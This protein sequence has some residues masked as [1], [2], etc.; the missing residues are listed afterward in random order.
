MT[1]GDIVFQGMQVPDILCHGTTMQFVNRFRQPDG[2]YRVDV[3]NE[4]CA[5]DGDVRAWPKHMRPGWEHATLVIDSFRAYE[6]LRDIVAGCVFKFDFLP[7]GSYAVLG[8]S[9]WR[10]PMYNN[11]RNSLKYEIAIDK[12][13]KCL[14][15]TRT[16]QFNF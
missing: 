12:L 8:E 6:G 5:R 14:R 11:D 4:I 16:I 1:Q 15:E 10:D 13:A 2:T 3:L 7:P 9:V